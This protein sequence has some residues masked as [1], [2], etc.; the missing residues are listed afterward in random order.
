MSWYNILK[1][2][3][4]DGGK[5]AA[6]RQQLG[7]RTIY[8]SHILLIRN[9]S[10][11][12]K[13]AQHEP[14]LTNLLHRQSFLLCAEKW[15]QKMKMWRWRKAKRLWKMTLFYDEGEFFL[16][17]HTCTLKNI[18]FILSQSFA[19]SFDIFCST[20]PGLQILKHWNCSKQPI[21]LDKQHEIM[22]WIHDI[23]IY[24]S[25]NKRFRISRIFTTTYIH[26]ITCPEHELDIMGGFHNKEKPRVGG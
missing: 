7:I 2:L 18:I 22:H 23:Q 3:I 14:S 24:F 1:L 5:I 17:L 6:R 13:L 10:G 9:S 11:H 20:K 4:I 15:L 12:Y 16:Y 8:Y 19:L 21:F 25:L 26:N